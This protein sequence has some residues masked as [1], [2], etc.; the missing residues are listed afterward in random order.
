M[1][2][3]SAAT[4]ELRLPEALLGKPRFGPFPSVT[5]ALKFL[6]ALALGAVV[7]ALAGPLF[8]LPFVG[9]GFLL[10][11]YR[12][13]GKSVDERCGD[14]L[15]WRFRP[16]H[17]APTANVGS[18]RTVYRCEGGFAAGVRAGG[19]PLAFLPVA[20]Q[21]ARFRAYRAL[22]DALAGSLWM[23]VD[24]SA[25]PTAPFLPR[26]SGAGDT[27]TSDAAAQRSYREFLTLL[28]RRRRRRVVRILL[29]EP[30]TGAV[31]L[32]RLSARV[33]SLRASLERLELP[34]ERLQGSELA[35]LAGSGGGWAE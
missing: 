32:G 7:A 22:L 31:S 24:T 17:G 14:Y 27:A 29:V 23:E 19:L 35:R 9:G 4:L 10:A 25:L 18:T 16:R 21:E 3:S 2:S 8:W 13:D 1:S 6:L 26:D 34:A 5:D 11:V 30:G 20:E 33:E 28:L 15:R 12:T